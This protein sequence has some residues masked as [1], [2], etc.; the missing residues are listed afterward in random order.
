MSVH[1]DMAIICKE[2]DHV[3]SDLMD[4]LSKHSVPPQI[5][6]K[7]MLFCAGASAGLEQ[8]PITGD[9]VIPSAIGWQRGV[10]SEGDQA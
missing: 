4:V 3:I 6:E 1:K 10:I 2:Y 9:W 7:I 8:R 5:G